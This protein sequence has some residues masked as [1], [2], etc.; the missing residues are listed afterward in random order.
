MATSCRYFFCLNTT[1][2]KS[3]GN[4]LPSPSSLPSHFWFLLL[5]FCFKHFFLASFSSQTEKKK[6]TIDKKKNV[7]KG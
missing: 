6:K 1:K 5:P 3:N 4:K 2:K 7:E